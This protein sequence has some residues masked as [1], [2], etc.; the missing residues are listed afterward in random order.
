L[1]FQGSVQHLHVMWASLLRM[2]YTESLKLDDFSV[3]LLIKEK[4][5][6]FCDTV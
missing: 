3:K 2:F 4:G 1:E 5:E 6:H